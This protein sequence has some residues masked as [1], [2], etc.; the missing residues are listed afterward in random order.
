M[1]AWHPSSFQTKIQ[2]FKFQLN[3]LNNIQVL[4]ILT[5]LGYLVPAVDEYGKFFTTLRGV[6]N[7]VG[8][9]TPTPRLRPIDIQPIED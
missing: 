3:R 5:F 6:Y 9:P 1:L 2:L 4:K 7:F 8:P